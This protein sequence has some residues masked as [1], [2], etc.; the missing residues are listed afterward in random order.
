MSSIKP[1]DTIGLFK[2]STGTKPKGGCRERRERER[3]SM[4]FTTIDAHLL[5]VKGKMNLVKYSWL[6]KGPRKKKNE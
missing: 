5:F 2:V 6:K 3:K 1:R 4:K